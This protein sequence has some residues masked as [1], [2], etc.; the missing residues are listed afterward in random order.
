MDVAILIYSHPQASR[1]AEAVQPDNTPEIRIKS[2]SE[3][4]LAV[5]LTKGLRT[6]LASCDDLFVNLQVARD[7]LS[8][9]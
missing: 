8:E 1:I 5:I 7:I 2:T 6:T 9:S 4:M 3:K